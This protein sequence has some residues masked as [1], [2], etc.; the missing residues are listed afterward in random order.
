[1]ER[2]F[3]EVIC[4]APTTLQGYVIAQKNELDPMYICLPVHNRWQNKSDIS[5]CRNVNEI[6]WNRVSRMHAIKFAKV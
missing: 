1:M 4:G 3:Y 5:K 6:C 2:D